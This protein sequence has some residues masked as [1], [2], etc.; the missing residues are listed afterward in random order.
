MVI[1]SVC[2]VQRVLPREPGGGNR[3]FAAMIA[4]TCAVLN[5]T[6]VTRN[7]TDFAEFSVR[8]LNPF[9]TARA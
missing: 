4:A 2:K 3:P 1:Q 9:K 6:V 5:L 7:V 8:V